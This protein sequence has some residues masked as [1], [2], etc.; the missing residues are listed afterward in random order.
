MNASLSNHTVVIAVRWLSLVV[1]ALLLFWQQRTLSDWIAFTVVVTL[2]ISMSLVMQTVARWAVRHTAILAVDVLVAAVVIAWSS[3]W[4]SPFLPYALAV[5][6]LPALISGWRGGLLAG[7]LLSSLLATLQVTVVGQPILDPAATWVQW[8]V[9]YLLPGAV[10]ALLPALLQLIRDANAPRYTR[11]M[12]LVLPPLTN[13]SE[14]F[15]DA[16]PMRR[17]SGVATTS[18]GVS[19]ATRTEAVR[20]ALYQPLPSE[21]VYAEQVAVLVDRFEQQTAIATRVVFLGRPQPIQSLHVPLLRRVL[22]ESLLNVEQHAQAT[23][24]SVLT[25]YDQRTVTVVVQD[26]GVGLP[27]SGIQRAGLHSMH[28]LM[29]RTSELGGRLEVFNN[30]SSGVAVRLVLPLLAQDIV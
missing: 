12:P 20:V 18:G 29:Y 30:A 5:L 23:S 6:V 2:N 13:L 25:R 3:L 8:L 4:G 27:I 11:T 15:R 21:Q 17:R 9:A 28:A 16:L 19:L 14:R 26:D 7:L 10:G 1:T 22:I 24:V